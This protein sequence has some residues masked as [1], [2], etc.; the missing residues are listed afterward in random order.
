M[1]GGLT[2]KLLSFEELIERT[3]TVAPKLG[4][5][6]TYKKRQSEIS[7]RKTTRLLLH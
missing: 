4:Q 2:T 7:N 6:V 5:T 3:D 1:S